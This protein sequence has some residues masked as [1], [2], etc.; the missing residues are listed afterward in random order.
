MKT[1]H[2]KKSSRGARGNLIVLCCVTFA[3]IALMLV[4]AYSLC[5]LYFV[6]NYLQGSANEI[7][8][9]GAKKINEKD[10]LGQMNNMIA[11]CRQLVY[12]SRE[13]YEKTKRELKDLEFFAE[14]LLKESRDSARE[15]ETQRKDLGDLARKEAT[16]A[17]QRQFD[18]IK[19]S[20]T[21]TLPWLR[22]SSP[23]LLTPKFGKLEGLESNVEELT[24]L[25]DLDKEDRAQNYVDVRSAGGP[26][27]SVGLDLY[28]AEKN[29]KLSGTNSEPSGADR[30]LDFKLSSLPA[31]VNGVIP[32]ARVLLAKA[33]RDSKSNTDYAPAVV[34]TEISVKVQTGLGPYASSQM[35]A[36]GTSITTG[37]SRQ[38]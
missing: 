26:G 27:G 12:S 20:Y 32:Q 23:R 38:L 11:R 6:H 14:P 21:V 2:Y 34:Q 28:K 33:F 24:E 16:E 5:G 37:A 13:E 29:L 30:D 35:S 36:R 22:I 31:P 3:V 15:L 17:M 4:V 9:A 7:A 1:S 8:L 25:T 10:R 18:C 19:S